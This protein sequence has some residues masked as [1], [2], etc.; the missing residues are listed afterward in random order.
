MSACRDRHS[1]PRSIAPMV[2]F[3]NFPRVPVQA[4]PRHL[5]PPFG[6][7]GRGRLALLLVATDDSVR[8]QGPDPVSDLVE[9]STEPS[10][11]LQ[12]V[13][14]RPSPAGSSIVRDT[15]GAVSRSRFPSVANASMLGVAGT[16]AGSGSDPAPPPNPPCWWRGRG[17]PILSRHADAPPSTRRLAPVMKEP[18]GPARKAA[19]EAT[20]SGDP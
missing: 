14:Q 18:S 19:R 15:N 10:C 3:W 5:P 2:M 6:W 11:G 12:Q 16:P 17:R 7:R 9:S 4:R 13:A 20:S 8:S 1:P